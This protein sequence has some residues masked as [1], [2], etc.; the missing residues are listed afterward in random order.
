MR[1]TYELRRRSLLQNA[2]RGRHCCGG[3]AGPPS[4]ELY[5]ASSLQPL[6]ASTRFPSLLC[7][8]QGGSD[9]LHLISVICRPHRLQYPTSTTSTSPTPSPSLELTTLPASPTYRLH[10]ASLLPHSP[11]ALAQLPTTTTTATIARFSSTHSL[12][13]HNHPTNI[14]RS[15]PRSFKSLDR[16]RPTTAILP[17][18]FAV[19]PSFR[20]S[21]DTGLDPTK[22]LPGPVCHHGYLHLAVVGDPQPP[23]AC[24]THYYQHALVAAYSRSCFSSQHYSHSPRMSLPR[25]SSSRRP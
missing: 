14:Q 23:L 24:I 8:T 18:Q 19:S 16:S 2:C 5:D 22:G 17:C 7:I 3:E 4:R 9:S 25:A 12:L 20:S 11:P 10:S 1:C 6:S 15:L 13:S 21:L